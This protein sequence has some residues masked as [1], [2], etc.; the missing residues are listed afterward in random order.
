[1]DN[2]N[3]WTMVIDEGDSDGLWVWSCDGQEVKVLKGYRVCNLSVLDQIPSNIIGQNS[4]NLHLAR[5]TQR[6]ILNPER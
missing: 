2:F 6:C 3:K 4:T 5:P 1:M